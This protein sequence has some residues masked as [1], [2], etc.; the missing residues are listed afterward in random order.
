M[1]VMNVSIEPAKTSASAE[2]PW[3]ARS[4]D[5]VLA[6]LESELHGLTT[7]EAARRAEAHGTNELPPP[8]RRSALVRFVVQFNNV[9]IYVLLGAGVVTAMLGHTTDSAVIFGVVVINAVIGFIQEGKAESALEA[10]RQML[11]PHALVMRDGHRID[12]PARELVPGDVVYLQS[13]DRVPADLRL[14]QTKGL[15]AQEAVLTG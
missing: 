15:R 7:A 14:L 4:H 11:A 10:I 3:H 6:C 12:L 5:E 1:N 9:L 13:G 2:I 8:P